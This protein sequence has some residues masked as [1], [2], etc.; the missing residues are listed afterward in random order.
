M[1]FDHDYCAL[2]V[3]IPGRAPVLASPDEDYDAG[4]KRQ[5]FFFDY[6]PAP[7]L[8]YEAMRNLRAI[9]HEWAHGRPRDRWERLQLKLRKRGVRERLERREGRHD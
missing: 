1:I 6:H 3:S 8:Q 9:L 2:W 4:P 5:E 7:Y